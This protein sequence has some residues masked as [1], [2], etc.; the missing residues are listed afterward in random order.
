MFKLHYLEEDSNDYRDEYLVV[1][2]SNTDQEKYFHKKLLL[3]YLT[4]LSDN[5]AE[6]TWREVDMNIGRIMSSRIIV[7]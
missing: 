2:L 7:L 1:D 3:D 4:H 6:N 5:N